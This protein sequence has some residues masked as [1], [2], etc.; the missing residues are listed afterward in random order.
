MSVSLEPA[1]DLAALRLPQGNQTYRREKSMTATPVF[2]LIWLLMPPT[3]Y[4]Q[5]MIRFKGSDTMGAKLVPQL[6][7]AYKTAYSDLKIEI[8]AEGSATAFKTLLDGTTD[9]GMSSREINQEEVKQLKRQQFQ[10]HKHL[11]AYDCLVIVVNAN[12]PVN[13]LTTKQ[14]EGLFTGD[15][16]NWK[17]VGGNDAQVTLRT[18]NTSSGSYKEFMNLAMNGRPY[19]ERSIKLGGGESP[20]QGVAKDV[21]ATT[22]CGLVHAKTKGI[23]TISINGIAPPVDRANNYP[24]IRP[25]FY[26]IRSDASPA[27][28]AFLEWAVQS[29]EA[30]SIVRKVGFLPAEK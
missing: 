14:I 12:N 11:A 22:Y 30:K 26:F 27:A 4:A 3:L 25:S 20:V 13:G 28:K 2:L 10:M 15:I 6:C 21:N 7:E 19:A 16:T 23:K 24:Y 29:A 9:I 5:E 8:A 1:A 17:D 18:R